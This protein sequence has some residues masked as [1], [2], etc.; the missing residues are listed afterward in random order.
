MLLDV[1]KVRL[2]LGRSSLVPRLRDGWGRLPVNRPTL[3]A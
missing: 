1:I 2:R 3:A